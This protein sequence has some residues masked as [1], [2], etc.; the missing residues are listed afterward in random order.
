[1][2]KQTDITDISKRLDTEGIRYIR[3][4]MSDLMGVPRSKTVPRNA[5]EGFARK[6]VNMYG[7]ALGLDSASFVVPDTGLAEESGYMDAFLIPD[8]TTLTQLPW[9][10]RSASLI[11]TPH[12]GTERVPLMQAPRNLLQVQLDKARD[13]GF[14]VKSG[15]ELE[16]Y[17][18]NAETK[19]PLFGGQ[20]IFVSSRNHYT[21]FINDLMDTLTEMGFNLTTHNVEYAP[22]QFE[23]NF[24]PLDG[25]AGADSAFR[26][27]SV[28]KEFAHK[29]GYLATFM[30]KPHAGLAGCGYHLHIGLNDAKTGENVFNDPKGQNGLSDNA[31]HFTAG[32][33][34][35]AMALAALMAPTINCYHRFLKGSFAPSRVTWGIED[36]TAMLRMKA[37]GDKSTHLE[38]R[39]GAGM[40]NPYL[41][42]ASVLAAGL[43][44]IEQKLTLDPPRPGL[45]ENDNTAP[46]LPQSLEQALACLEEDSDLVAALGQPFVHLFTTVKRY[47]IDRWRRHISDWERNEYLELY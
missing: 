46:Y 9:D 2:N 44:G 42:Q 16:F 13:M 41:L 34:N 35:H 18:Y 14:S 12:W 33:R 19:E 31:L 45:A 1:M 20:H 11:C 10:P 25:I 15:H 5:F 47:E 8:L 38:M 23:L 30:S 43:I 21:G 3:F 39:G 22:S 7:G 4:E 32:I 17:L 24:A 28:V 27:K 36:R 29:N 40:A 26:F 37:S 6:G